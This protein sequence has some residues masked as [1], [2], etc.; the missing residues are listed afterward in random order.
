MINSRRRKNT[1]RQRLQL[2]LFSYAVDEKIRNKIRWFSYC[3][4]SPPRLWKY[5]GRKTK[6]GPQRV[7][8]PGLL[9]IDPSRRSPT[10]KAMSRIKTIDELI[11]EKGLTAEELERHRDL[12]EECK[13][14][15]MEIR[16]S[17]MASARSLQQLSV[18]LG[19]LENRLILLRRRAEDLQDLT[20]RLYLKLL[21]RQSGYRH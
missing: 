16:D 1:N 7:R 8:P 5:H 11:C 15:E 20:S 6:R 4:S 21:P 18:Q 13:L 12:I 9:I 14:R 10:G 2:I 19:E 17:S 3:L